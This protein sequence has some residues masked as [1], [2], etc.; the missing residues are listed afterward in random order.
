M[1]RLVPRRLIAAAALSWWALGSAE[2]ADAMA[3]PDAWPVRLDGITMLCKLAGL[4]HL[5]LFPEQEPH[6]RPVE[7]Q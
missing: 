7:D 4:W 3:V 2:P 5:G 1:E 6:W